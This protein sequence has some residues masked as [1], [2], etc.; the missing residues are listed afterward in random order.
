MQQIP[1]AVTPSQAV[2]IILNGQNCDI[3]I[4]Q[5]TTGLFCDLSIDSAV[6]WQGAVCINNMPICN[7][8]YL[9][10]IGKLTFYDTLGLENPDY[11][12][13]A[14]RFQFL[15]LAPGEGLT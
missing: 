6:V 7:Y 15:Y 10:F 4:Y 2:K 1:L 5:K 14:S 12:G 8:D 13:F 11:T 9:P 3:S